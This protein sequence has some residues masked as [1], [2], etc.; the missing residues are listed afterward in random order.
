MIDDEQTHTVPESAEGLAQIACFAGY[1]DTEPFAKELIT[2]LECVQRHY[3]ELFEKAPPLGSEGGSLVFTGVEDDP[4]TLETL[5]EMGFRDAH[6]IA[7]AIRG[8]HHGRI[9]ATRSSRAR[10]LLTRLMPALLGALAETADP[11]SAF[12][13]FDRFVSRLPAGVQLFS[14]FLANPHLLKLVAGIMGSAPRLAE[15]L[16]VAPAM[17]DVLLDRGFVT[18]FSESSLRQ[19][20][21]TQLA[22]ATDQEAALDIVRRFVR[23]QSFRTGVQLIESS[24]SIGDAGAAFTAI[25]ESAIAGLLEKVE[26]ELTS[27]AGLVQGGSFCVVA[28]GRLGGREMTSASDLDLIFIYDAP[29]QIEF[30]S[31]PRRL[32]VM[33]YYAKLAQ[34]LIAALTVQTA[35]GGLYEVDMRLRPT[36]NKGPAA[37]SLESFARYHAE[38]AWT[39]ER[40]ALTRARVIA[41]PGGLQRRVEEVIRSSLV[42]KVDQGRLAHEASD[43]RKKLEMQFSARDCWNLKFVRGGLVDIEFVTEFLQ[44]RHAWETPD[45]LEPNTI[46]ALGRLRASGFLS[47]SDAQI[48]IDTARLELDLLQILRLAVAGTFNPERATPA[49]KALLLRAAGAEDFGA[50]EQRLKSAEFATCAIFDKLLPS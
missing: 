20:L 37:V 32:P 12:T 42:R 43:M 17:L 5:A 10:E 13:Q 18:D 16:A 27:S 35:E 7:G 50:L 28:M 40:L 14:L 8:W 3:E 31:G 24:I 47:E 34:R 36:G 38:D 46:S 21:I 6:H 22:A 39:W 29:P 15:H 44:L 25:A 4:E 26:H 45:I 19:L 23:E 2:N 49:M 33:V 1:A 30:S 41:G 9:R 11:D 48:L